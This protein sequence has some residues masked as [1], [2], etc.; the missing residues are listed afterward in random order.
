MVA[1]R[2]L[3]NRLDR[4]RLS[5]TSDVTFAIAKAQILRTCQM[6]NVPTG[7]QRVLTH[8]NELRT[9]ADIQNEIAFSARRAR[10]IKIQLECEIFFGAHKR[11]G[12]RAR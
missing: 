3:P 6:Q 11:H 5:I 7:Y 4:R 8:T 10:A 9:P 12:V 1:T 2:D